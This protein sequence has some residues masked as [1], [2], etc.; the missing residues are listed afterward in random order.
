MLKILAT[1][2]NIRKKKSEDSNKRGKVVKNNNEKLL[3][4]IFDI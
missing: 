4:A 1:T 3:F 2:E